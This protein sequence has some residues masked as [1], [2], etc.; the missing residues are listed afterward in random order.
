MI[1]N[2]SYAAV[3]ARKKEALG[4]TQHKALV[5]NLLDRC[6]VRVRWD[7]GLV[8]QS[9]SAWCSQPVE[10]D[11]APLLL[12]LEEIAAKRVRYG[13]WRILRLLRR[14]GWKANHKLVYRL[15]CQADLNLRRRRPRRRK[16]LARRLDRTM[17]TA[18]N[19]LWSMDFV[20]NA[21][22]DGRRFR[23]LTVVD[24][25]TKQTLVTEVN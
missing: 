4:L 21:S 17:L 24:S 3:C 5:G 11:D 10:D 23:A 7:S 1:L 13:F 12:Q 6:R 9:R 18:P 19:E 8:K 14:E 15:Y 20:A 25:F 22:F 2:H 16:A